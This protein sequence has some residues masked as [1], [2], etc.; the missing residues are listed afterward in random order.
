[1]IALDFSGRIH[2]MKFLQ[3]LLVFG[4]ICGAGMFIGGCGKKV[5]VKQKPLIIVFF[6]DS[7]TYG[8]G[9][10]NPSESFFGRI[11]N[12]INAGVY[13]NVRIIN[14]GVSGDDTDEAFTRISSVKAFDPDIVI[15]AFGLNDCQNQHL[16]PSRFRQNILRMINT[17]PPKTRIVLATSNTFMETGQDIWKK[18]N[19]SLVVYMDELRS[20]ARNRGYL[21]VDVHKVWK[22]QL[23]LD[24]RLLESLY[25]DP[26]HPS[27]K[28]HQLIYETYMD[29]LRK[30]MI[31]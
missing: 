17:F 10:S 1:M 6:G 14:A 30:L 11:Q 20:I 19:L 16:D 13:E 4:V 3:L 27:A 23:H 25:V 9:L 22:E 7:V 18:L 24:S 29:V 28:G 15:F 2:A 5:E 12:I 26:T 31:R 8:Y 21:L